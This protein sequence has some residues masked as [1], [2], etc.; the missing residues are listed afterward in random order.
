MGESTARMRA[1][2]QRRR[3]SMRLI[4]FRLAE[5]EIEALVSR[6]YLDR[7]DCDD[8]TALQAAAEAAFSDTLTAE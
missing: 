7:Q 5:A 1:L 3:Q 6:G 8:V 2:R 4:R